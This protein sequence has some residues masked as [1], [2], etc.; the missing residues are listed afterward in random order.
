MSISALAQNE[1]IVYLCPG[2]KTQYEYRIAGCTDH[3][4]WTTPTGYYNNE[5]ITISWQDTGRYVIIAE[6]IDT[7]LCSYS[8][9]TIEV[10]VME[11]NAS[12]IWFPNSFTP[13][14]DGLNDLFDIKGYN[15]LSY[16]LIIFNRWGEE[17][18]VTRDLDVQWDAFY[19][20]QPVPEGIYMYT[21]KWQDKT[22]RWGSR[23]GSITL[24]R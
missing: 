6:Y 16:E 17:L 11:C 23:T 3:L 24:I 8:K 14:S 15:L 13:N 1:Q 10:V 2:E 19:M 21:A 12:A 22:G 20:G 18:F 4:Y 7:S 5:S 9:K